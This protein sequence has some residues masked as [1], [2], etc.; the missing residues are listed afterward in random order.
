MV[1]IFMICTSPKILFGRSKN[2]EIG[3]ACST[4]GRDRER[5][6]RGVHTVAGKSEGKRPRGR[7]GVG[8]RIMFKWVLEKCNEGH[9]LA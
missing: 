7:P 4:Y 2:N 9:G 8:G 1:H 6:K 5:G 3:K